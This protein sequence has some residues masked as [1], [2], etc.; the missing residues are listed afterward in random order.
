[1][2]SSNNTSINN[3]NRR[4]CDESIVLSAVKNEYSMI[5]LY[6]LSRTRNTVLVLVRCRLVCIKIT[7]VLELCYYKLND[8][9]NGK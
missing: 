3:K 1:M 7:F 5:N 6:L 8:N 9:R 2:L 4:L